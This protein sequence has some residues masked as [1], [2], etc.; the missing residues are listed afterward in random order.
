MNTPEDLSMCSF[1]NSLLEKILLKSTDSIPRVMGIPIMKCTRFQ[2]SSQEMEV[3]SISSLIVIT[4]AGWI[5]KEPLLP[6]KFQK[7]TLTQA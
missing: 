1:K 6:L 7:K 5:G 3:C 2:I 4:S